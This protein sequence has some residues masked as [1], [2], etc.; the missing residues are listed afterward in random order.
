MVCKHYRAKPD[1]LVQQHMSIK[2]FEQSVWA[3]DMLNLS[4]SLV[5]FPLLEIIRVN[6]WLTALSLRA[7]RLTDAGV[8]AVAE[9]VQDLQKLQSLDLSNNDISEDSRDL[10]RILVSGHPALTEIVLSDPAVSGSKPVR[11]LKQSTGRP[12]LQVNMSPTLHDAPSFRPPEESSTGRLSTAE[13]KDTHHNR[14]ESWSEFSDNSACAL[15]GGVAGNSVIEASSYVRP[16]NASPRKALVSAPSGLVDETPDFSREHSNVDVDSFDKEENDSHNL[17]HLDLILSPTC[18]QRSVANASTKDDSAE[19]KN[20]QWPRSGAKRALTH[21]MQRPSAMKKEST[22]NF[23]VKSVLRTLK[24]PSSNHVELWRKLEHYNADHVFWRTEKILILLGEKLLQSGHPSL[25]YA[26]ALRA[27]ASQYLP[28]DSVGLGYIWAYAL[29]K[30]AE[31]ARAKRVANRLLAQAS[32]FFL[33]RVYALNGLH[34]KIEYERR[35]LGPRP[36]PQLQQVAKACA[37]FYLD[38]Y[39]LNGGAEEGVNA[40]TMLRVGQDERAREVAEN[41]MKRLKS[42]DLMK[43]SEGFYEYKIEAWL[44]E[45]SLVLD[46]ISDAEQHYSR[47][48]ELLREDPVAGFTN[49]FVEMAQNARM[50]EREG[51]AT[52]RVLDMFSNKKILLFL[53]PSLDPPAT[54]SSSDF[55]TDQ[56]LLAFPPAIRYESDIYGRLGAVPPEECQE[57]DEASD[58]TMITCFPSDDASLERNI[59]SEIRAK[60]DAVKPQVAFCFATSGSD[61]IFAESSL[62]RRIELHV[63]LP[64]QLD[65]FLDTCVTHGLPSRVSWADRCIKVLQRAHVHYTSTERYLDD[66]LLYDFGKLVMSGM[67]IL[68][69]RDMHQGSNS[70]CP[71]ALCLVDQTAPNYKHSQE[72]RFLTRW[73]D[74]HRPLEVIDLHQIKMNIES[75]SVS[76]TNPPATAVQVFFTSSPG[77]SNTA[78]EDPGVTPLSSIPFKSRY[79]FV[80]VYLK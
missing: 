74:A 69:S 5:L 17:D 24:S 47:A 7:S 75:A 32:P 59:S 71:V 34:L 13:F 21:R 20:S 58:S 54:F 26:L 53:G 55:S 66:Q 72:S 56:R 28:K 45:C 40:A 38:A 25:A 65:D 30:N 51:I 16:E 15:D 6:P 50:F 35:C 42:I 61:L 80:R 57:R 49:V 70:L 19:D 12:I 44:G 22:K 23:M 31:I 9:T 73:V 68:N 1:P 8:K 29:T 36:D 48:L 11:L 3:F 52:G 27:R 10:L 46:Q 62:D 79:I 63:V 14:G 4:D 18:E 76:N 43:N 60:L 77:D 67:A 37:R 2:G 78:A 39:K 64:F 33:D 41:V